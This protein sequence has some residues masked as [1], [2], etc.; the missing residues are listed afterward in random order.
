MYLTELHLFRDFPQDMHY[1][2]HSEFFPGFK[3]SELLEVDKG[4][5]GFG[6]LKFFP[7][8]ATDTL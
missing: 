4:K 8:L 7:R 5:S 1:L 2:L 6:R 3:P